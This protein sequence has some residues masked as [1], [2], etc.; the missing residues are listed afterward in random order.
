[1]NIDN[2]LSN[3]NYITQNQKN[4]DKVLGMI[5][6]G[7]QARLDDVASANIATM[8]QS[9]ISSMG[10]GLMN[11]NDGVAMMQIADGTASGL[12]ENASK[13]EA[14]S[15][16]YNS[17]SLNS[18]NRAALQNEF[19]A[20]T[21]SMQQSVDSTTYNGKQL[22]GSSGSIETSQGSVPASIGE[23]D[24]SSLDITSQESIQ[25]FQ[26]QLASVQSDIGSNTN[27]MS[28]SINSLQAAML[29]T[30]YAESQLS[31]TDIAEAVN[32]YQQE[33]LKLEAATLAQVH[34]TDSVQQQMNRLLG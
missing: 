17:A 10:Q 13:L 28:S 5:A 29:S 9:E 14:M 11:L 21:E 12:S 24:L 7:H 19:N 33:S 31:D 22:F 1:M 4:T 25:A 16:R 27:A 6:S 23:I 3:S 18:Q 8:M 15:V 2:S 26:D 30:S 20:I 34:K 32:Q